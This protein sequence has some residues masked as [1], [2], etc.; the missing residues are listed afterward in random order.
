[1]NDDAR[2]AEKANRLYWETDRSVNQIAEEMNV[3]KGTLYDLVHPLPA[4][5]PCPAC[6]EEMAWQN[7]TAREGGTITCSACEMEEEEEVVR[8][9]W[10]EAAGEEGGV[11]VTPGSGLLD[12]LPEEGYSL[13]VV[14]GG[15]LLGLAAGLTIGSLGRGR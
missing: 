9:S 14:L 2:L 6:G 4:G 8:E 5:L 12:T 1:M 13:R 3:S 11:V 7:R 15:A 10:H